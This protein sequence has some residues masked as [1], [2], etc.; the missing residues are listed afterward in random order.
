MRA[1]KQAVSRFPPVYSGNEWGG[2][3]TRAEINLD[4]LAAN[5]RNLKRQA[6]ASRLLTVVKADGYGHGAAAVGKTAVGAGADWLGVYTVDEG[7][8]LRRNGIDAPILIIGTFQSAEARHIVDERLTPTITS[9]QAAAALQ[10]AAG[11]E[12]IAFHV[13]TDTGLT[14]AG[15]PVDTLES[16]ARSLQEFPA[17]EP[18]GLYTHFASADEDDKTTTFDQFRVFL[19]VSDRLAEEGLSFPLRHVANSAATL[20]LPETHLDMVRCGITCYGYYPSP[21]V[22]RDVEVRPAMSLLS[23]VTRVRR[24]PTGTG[25]GYGHEFRCSR[26]SLI[27]LVPIG[28]GD[29]LPRCLGSG[30]GTV[31]LR[32]RAVPI[33]GRMSMDQIAVDATDVP[34]VEPGDA[35]TIIGR[36]GE[37][38]QSAD[39]L[40]RQAG[41]ISYDIL[42]GIMPRV[43]RVYIRSGAIA[44]D[45]RPYR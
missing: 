13:K 43:P 31:L 26:E 44:G 27:A 19:A 20:D 12:R 38:E 17:L 7:V 29:G 33:V 41:T 36:D 18:Q 25:V 39:D 40:A 6:G 9:L 32:G 21:A 42:T 8:V 15:V 2:R 5:I 10:D 22:R 45:S 37:V 28:Y 35:V 23:A 16:F 11:G 4:S 3:V 1:H 34:A 24:V 30:I 14:R